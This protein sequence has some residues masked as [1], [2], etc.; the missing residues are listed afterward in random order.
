ME[1]REDLTHEI[2]ELAFFNGELMP[3]SDV[4]ISP[5]DRGFLFA[6][7]VYE[8]VPVYNRKPFFFDIA[9]NKINTNI[10]AAGQRVFG[11]DDPV[12]SGIANTNVGR[13]VVA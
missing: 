10:A 1:E 3:L 13:Q 7:G 4:K 6:D 12:F 2:S 8:V 9:N 5:L 11:T